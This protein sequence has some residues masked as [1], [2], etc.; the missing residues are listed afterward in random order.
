M[1]VNGT[2]NSDPVTMRKHI[3][4]FVDGMVSY[5]LKDLFEPGIRFNAVHFTGAE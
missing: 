1:Y 2:R 4:Y 3:L 5:S